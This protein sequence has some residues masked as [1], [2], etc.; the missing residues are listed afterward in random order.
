MDAILKPVKIFFMQG[1]TLE[2][3]GRVARAMFPAVFA[4]SVRTELPLAH[5][6]ARPKSQ[7]AKLAWKTARDPELQ[8]IL[9]RWRTTT[10]VGVMS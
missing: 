8:C 6:R 1:A 3:I 7:T 4:N 2:P 5:R 9:L 10:S